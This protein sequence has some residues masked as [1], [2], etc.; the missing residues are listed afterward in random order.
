MPSCAPRKLKE[1]TQYAFTFYCSLVLHDKGEFRLYILK[2]CGT[3]NSYFMKS[4]ARLVYK[5]KD[6][7]I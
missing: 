2:F 7:E 1:N 6:R 3:I 4:H 5:G